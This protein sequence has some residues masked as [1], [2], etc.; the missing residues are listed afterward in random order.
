MVQTFYKIV[1]CVILISLMSVTQPKRTDAIWARTAPAGSLVVDG[2]LNEAAWSKA[3]SLYVQYGKSAG[4]P[5][6][7]YT[8]ET[9][10][11]FD[12][13]R[14]WV[15]FLVMGDS[16]Y[17]AFTVKDSSIGGGNFGAADAIIFNIR[18]K[19][20]LKQRPAPS[21]EFLYGW[22]NESWMNPGAVTAVGGPPSTGPTGKYTIK[23]FETATT[24]QGI[25]N[26]DAKPDTG[27]TV[28]MKINIKKL[29]YNTADP[30]GDIVMFNVAF[31]DVDWFFPVQDWVTFSRT[32]LQG[33][34]ANVSNKNFLRIHVRPDITTASGAAPKLL[35]EYSLQNGKLM[36]S[37]TI[38]GKLDEA[39]WG[40]IQGIDIRFGDNKIRNAY[41]S[42]GP[43]ASGE[44]QPPVNG[45]KATVFDSSKANVKMFFKGNTLYVGVDV[46]DQ[47]VQFLDVYDRWDGFMITM[48][49]MGKDYQNQTD[50]DQIPMKLTVI[51][52]KNGKDSLKDY[53]P[54]FRDSLHGAQIAL[55]LKPNTTLDTTG[56]DED[57]G[58]QIEQAIDLTKMGYPSGL[59]DGV[60]YLGLT[61]FD[62]DSY[63]PSSLSYGT[64]TWW[65]REHEG[66][67]AAAYVYMDTT[68]LITGVGKTVNNALPTEFIIL[69]NY[70]NPFNPS[71]NIKFSSPTDGRVTLSVFDILGRKISST[72]I[73]EFQ[74]GQHSVPFN[75]SK[76][77]TGVYFYQL[78]LH[79]GVTGKEFATPFSK[80]VLLK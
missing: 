76:L 4:L 43:F 37:P 22:I 62:G 45:G 68:L 58:Y 59:G 60:L 79:S 6:S 77:S 53:Y 54:K 70:P 57:A 19:S 17:L 38:D 29:G 18:D 50:H 65:F 36:T 21:G 69:G 74:S 66:F 5:G 13:T 11:V 41:A 32:W 2:K 47:A 26:T 40:K 25:T 30:N 1:T 15:K 52:G 16:L 20:D 49:G 27:Y 9:G 28:E 64:R 23:D 33:P 46:Q 61:L 75:A 12:S 51:V 71:T 63:N 78:H 72:D 7:G 42:V 55:T 56:I 39:V 80:M 24:V 31:R 34:W 3:E 10:T 35:P 44:F 48:N 14:A 8:A 73:G 67:A